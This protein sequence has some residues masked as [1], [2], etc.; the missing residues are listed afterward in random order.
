MKTM[1]PGKIRD[2]GISKSSASIGD[3]VVDC[4]VQIFWILSKTM[5]LFL[6]KITVIKKL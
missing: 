1:I 2:D 6:K 5:N 4:R 3:I